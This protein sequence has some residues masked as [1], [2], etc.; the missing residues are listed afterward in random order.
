MDGTFLKPLQISQG[1][2]LD[3]C[4]YCKGN[5]LHQGTISVY[6]PDAPRIEWNMDPGATQKYTL[7]TRVTHV[8]DNGTVTT[9]RVERSATNN[10]SQEREG[11]LVEFYCETCDNKPTLAIF[12]HKGTT[13]IGWTQ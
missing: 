8:F 10:P 4:P 3:E 11:L 2:W 12:Q 9:A 13:F 6:N 7:M 1:D 5:N